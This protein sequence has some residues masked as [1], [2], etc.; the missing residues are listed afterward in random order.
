MRKN[1]DLDIFFVPYPR[2]PSADNYYLTLDNFGYLVPAGSKNVE[3]SCIF[4][5]CVRMSK[6][7]EALKETT[8]ESIM[9]NKKYTDEQFEFWS[10]FQD[11]SNFENLV[12]DYSTCFE[13]TVMNDVMNPMLEDTL[14]DRN[15]TGLSWTTMRENNIGNIDAQIADINAMINNNQ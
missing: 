2:D 7:D 3:A 9:K 15:S 13:S 8:R 12:I 4:I 14:F 1:E 5:N 11:P 6:T 10:Y